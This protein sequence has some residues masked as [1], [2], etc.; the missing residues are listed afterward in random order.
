MGTVG[1]RRPRQIVSLVSG[2]LLEENSNNFLTVLI[3]R[4]IIFDM[5]NIS[6]LNDGRAR[7]ARLPHR[8]GE[9]DVTPEFEDRSRAERPL[10][11]LP[12]LGR[13]R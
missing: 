6:P 4:I 9:F 3:L 10:A 13:R 11:A 2:R 1:A 8:S 5:E 12:A 7:R